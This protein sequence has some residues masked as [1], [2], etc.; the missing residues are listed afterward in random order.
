MGHDFAAIRPSDDGKSAALAYEFRKVS[1]YVPTSIVKNDL[2]YYVTDNGIMC[3]LHVDTGEVVWKQRLDG[4]FFGSFVCA[5]NKLV[6]LSKEGDAYVIAASDKF[7]LLGHNP[8]QVEEE[9]TRCRP[10]RRRRRLR[11]GGFTSARTI[12]W[13]VLGVRNSYAEFV[14][15]TYP[16]RGAPSPDRYAAQLAPS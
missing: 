1:P 8:L 16:R 3:C 2:L 15:W 4:N 11:T 12:T 9:G 13:R 6:I 14:L 5:G 7:E 10:S